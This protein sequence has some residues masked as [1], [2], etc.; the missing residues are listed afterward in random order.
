MPS[1]QPHKKPRVW[2]NLQLL[3]ENSVKLL[4]NGNRSPLL[5]KGAV[6]WANS[7]VTSAYGSIF[8]GVI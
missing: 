4:P 2:K 6:A 8:A 5:T 7:H 1:L 3:A